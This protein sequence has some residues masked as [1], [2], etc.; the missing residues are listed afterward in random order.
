M[1][2]RKEESE[3]KK[4]VFEKEL[5]GEGMWKWGQSERNNHPH[6]IHRRF[7]EILK[8]SKKRG[9]RR[10]EQARREGSKKSYGAA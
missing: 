2:S 9:E 5:E 3:K 1:G 10:E 7:Q 8:R 4:N 6:A